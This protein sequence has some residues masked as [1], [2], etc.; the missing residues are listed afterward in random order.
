MACMRRPGTRGWE[1]MHVP[2]GHLCYPHATAAQWPVPLRGSLP[3][4]ATELLFRGTSRLWCEVPPRCCIYRHLHSTTRHLIVPWP[5]Q[6]ECARSSA[7]GWHPGALAC[8]D[9]LPHPTR[10]HCNVNV[11]L[12][13]HIRRDL[14]QLMCFILKGPT[15]SKGDAA[16]TPPSGS[17]M[18]LAGLPHECLQAM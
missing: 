12:P 18:Q 9:G 17:R 6:R 16:W 11:R 2:P 7:C 10:P 13:C 3:R 4:V 5:G 1:H 8:H 14:D 15:S